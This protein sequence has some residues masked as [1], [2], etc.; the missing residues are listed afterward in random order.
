MLPLSVAHWQVVRGMPHVPD[1]NMP[2]YKHACHITYGNNAWGGKASDMQSLEHLIHGQLHLC[3]WLIAA[4]CSHLTKRRP[5]VPCNRCKVHLY[6]IV[7]SYRLHGLADCQH[8]DLW[9]SVKRA[10]Q[11]RSG[12]LSCD[13]S[14]HYRFN[15]NRCALALQ[16]AQQAQEYETA[17]V[18]SHLQAS[19]DLSVDTYTLSR[20][21][22]WSSQGCLVATVATFH[23]SHADTP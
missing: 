10:H 11:P 3:V 15:G 23:V 5:T 19:C 7:A 21:Y 2:A 8:D 16:C 12:D 22:Q 9:L 6:M 18:N 1:C 20:K 14:D 17:H 13:R 4:G